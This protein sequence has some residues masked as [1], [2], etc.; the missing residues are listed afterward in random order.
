MNRRDFLKG[1]AA[2]P[3][4]DTKAITR[5]SFRRDSKVEGVAEKSR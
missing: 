1:L 2:T 3:A 4:A 5:G